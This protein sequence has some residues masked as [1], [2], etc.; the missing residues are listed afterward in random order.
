MKFEQVS[1]L[2]IIYTTFAG[3]V[4]RAIVERSRDLDGLFESQLAQS[5]DSG[6]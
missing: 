3:V 2:E 6:W 1:M 4:A 5:F